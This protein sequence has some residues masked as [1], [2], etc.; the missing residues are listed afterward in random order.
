MSLILRLRTCIVFGAALAIGQLAEGSSALVRQDSKA[1]PLT[2]ATVKT[3]PG[4]MPA[5][6]SPVQPSSAITILVAPD[7]LSPTELTAVRK[8]LLA[9]GI[10]P[11]LYCRGPRWRSQTGGDLRL[12]RNIS[13]LFRLGH[14]ISFNKG[15]AERIFNFGRRRFNETNGAGCLFSVARSRFEP[16]T[17]Q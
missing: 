7:T 4:E 6:V 1:P 13:N 15:Y 2:G 11:R 5:S 9:E 3:Y 12:R 8:E 14:L 10:G 16:G 17:K